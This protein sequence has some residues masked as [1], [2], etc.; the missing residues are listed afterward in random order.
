MKIAILE[1]VWAAR[2]RIARKNGY[3]LRRTV[4]YLRALETK[5][6][7]RVVAFKP[8]KPDAAWLSL[9]PKARSNA[10]RK[11]AVVHV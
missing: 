11:R 4:E 8:K 9:P 6:P 10:R 7:G 5:Y 3:N 2:D 1:E